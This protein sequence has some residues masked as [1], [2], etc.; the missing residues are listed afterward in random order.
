MSF[1]LLHCV[2]ADDQLVWHAIVFLEKALS[3]SPSNFQFKLLLI[4]LYSTLG[5]SQQMVV[6]VICLSFIPLHFHCQIISFC[7]QPFL[8]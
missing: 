8:Q 7:V 6:V 5:W 2:V 3:K 4:R 1:V